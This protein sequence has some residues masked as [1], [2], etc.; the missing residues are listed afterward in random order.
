MLREVT[1]EA[2]V[3]P[4][5]DLEVAPCSIP[6]RP[7]TA[8]QGTMAKERTAGQLNGLDV[9]PVPVEDRHASDGLGGRR[10][11]LTPVEKADN[12]LDP[13]LRHIQH[14]SAR[15]PVAA[16]QRDRPEI[17]CPDD[18]RRLGDERIARVLWHGT[19]IGS[20]RVSLKPPSGTPSARPSG[21]RLARRGRSVPPRTSAVSGPATHPVARSARPGPATAVSVGWRVRRPRMPR[22]CLR[23]PP[24]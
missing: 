9:C 23:P 15:V 19:S 24:R 17:T 7:A 11:G 10:D 2:G 22:G 4:V 12:Q 5:L 6:Q 1:A 13:A 3:R 20:P 8:W 21:H 14:L 16:T 18:R